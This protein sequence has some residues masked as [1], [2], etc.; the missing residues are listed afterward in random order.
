MHPALW[1]FGLGQRETKR[2]L[3]DDEKIPRDSAQARESD[4]TLAATPPPHA[5]NGS[6]RR[7]TARS[8]I[9]PGGAPAGLGWQWPIT[10]QTTWGLWGSKTWQFDRVVTLYS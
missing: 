8:V 5:A 1:L 9:G 3:G 7:R 2:A 4:M 10:T 6:A